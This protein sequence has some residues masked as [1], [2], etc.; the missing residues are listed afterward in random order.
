MSPVHNVDAS[1]MNAA[2]LVAAVALLLGLMS[3]P[4]AAAPGAGA[5]RDDSSTGL[6]A[7]SESDAAVSLEPIFHGSRGDSLVA[8]TF[9][10]CPARGYDTRIVDYL[11]RN[12]I[13]ATLFLTGRWIEKFGRGETEVLVA[14]RFEIANH[15]WSHPD[16]A[17]LG[18]AALLREIER[19]DSAIRSAGLVPTRFFRFPFGKY[20]RANLKALAAGGWIAV[21]W[22]AAGDVD[23]G[24]T[25]Q[26]LA[27]RILRQ[28]RSGSIVLLHVNSRCRATAE[29]VPLIVK[30]LRQK[31]LRP[32]ALSELAP[33][34]IR[35]G[36]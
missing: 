15:S 13:P 3:G 1:R 20:N 18:S 16:C 17:R 26:R 25:P 30:G 8:L 21:Q 14:G 12:E 22:D 10:F 11:R 31:G 27:D 5:E 23:K 7:M 9:D 28:V 36:E 24:L 29:A 35:T 4:A 19:C 33:A 6:V 34:T 32:A 2:C